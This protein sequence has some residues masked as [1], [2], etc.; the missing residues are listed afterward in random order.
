MQVVISSFQNTD[1]DF[2]LRQREVTN[3]VLAGMTANTMFGVYG[4]ICI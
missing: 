4:E 3:L 1:L 2:Q